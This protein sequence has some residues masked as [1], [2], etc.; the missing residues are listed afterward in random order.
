M[1][2]FKCGMC[3]FIYCVCFI[4]GITVFIYCVCLFI[5]CVCVC[6]LSHVAELVSL[7]EFLQL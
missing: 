1:Y 2:L 5:V 3:V 7:W 6:A 4:S